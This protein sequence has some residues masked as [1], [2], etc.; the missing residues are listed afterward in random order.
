[1]SERISWD[2]LDKIDAGYVAY[3][4]GTAKIHKDT[5]QGINDDV[6]VTFTKPVFAVS[7]ADVVDLFNK[8][9]TV[10]FNG[11]LNKA[12]DQVC[13]G[14]AVQVKRAEL[15]ADP[16]KKELKALAIQ[17]FTEAEQNTYV[18]ARKAGQTAKQALKLIL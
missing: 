9:G 13:R 3:V 1:M 7:A 4:T 18:E 15:T 5:A 6:P 17:D 11:M 8:L 12:A 10:A 2:I 14:A 16:L